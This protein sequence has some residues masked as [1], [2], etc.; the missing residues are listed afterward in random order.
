MSGDLECPWI[1]K[2]HFN[3][4]YALFSILIEDQGVFPGIMDPLKMSFKRLPFDI[5]R[6]VAF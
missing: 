6:E 2:C 5:S 4:H 3:L 1:K